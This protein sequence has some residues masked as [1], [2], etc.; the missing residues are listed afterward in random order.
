MSLGPDGANIVDMPQESKIR[1]DSPVDEHTTRDRRWIGWIG[2][3]RNQGVNVNTA[4]CQKFVR[5]YQ[6]RHT[7]IIKQSSNKSDGKSTRRLGNW[8]K[9]VDV[10]AGTGNQGD[11]LLWHAELHDDGAVV[12]ILD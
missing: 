10:D 4:S 2:F 12:G 3:P 9:N 1:Y 8:R 7:L 11:S 6:R 5:A